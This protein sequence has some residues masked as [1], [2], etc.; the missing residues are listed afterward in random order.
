M[1]V[2]LGTVFID[3]TSLRSMESSHLSPRAGAKAPH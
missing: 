2:L 1:W 3:A